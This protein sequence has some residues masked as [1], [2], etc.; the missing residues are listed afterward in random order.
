MNT[1][2]PPVTIFGWLGASI[3]YGVSI[4]LV[5]IALLF[6]T[7]P[8]RESVILLAGRVLTAGIL[9]RWNMHFYA[10]L[11]ERFGG[12]SRSGFGI[13]LWLSFAGAVLGV[14]CFSVAGFLG[15]AG[16]ERVVQSIQTS[17]TTV[18][19][20]ENFTVSYGGLWQ[21]QDETCKTIDRSMPTEG[22]CQIA[23]QRGTISLMIGRVEDAE[24]AVA[25]EE[26]DEETMKR[27]G[28]SSAR[29]TTYEGKFA[30]KR[31]V[32]YPSS[33]GTVFAVRYV[34]EDGDA[35]LI[36]LFTDKKPDIADRSEQLLEML[37]FNN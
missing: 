8:A 7:L 10:R 35:I 6:S 36:V 21:K 11:K 14:V 18:F 37:K 5:E 20:G 31:E 13:I 24:G 33:G 29:I 15:K 4:A 3:I 27:A 17:S 30:T 26:A 34:I 9:L 12:K 16:G 22:F 28:A 1:L 2:T 23:L 32:S 19:E 25:F